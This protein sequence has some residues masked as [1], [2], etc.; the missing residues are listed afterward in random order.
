[1]LV[2]D[3]MTHTDMTAMLKTAL[4]AWA[5]KSRGYGPLFAK[6]SAGAHEIMARALSEMRVLKP[7]M[8]DW[9]W[10]NEHMRF[11]GTCSQ[12]ELTLVHEIMYYFLTDLARGRLEAKEDADKAGKADGISGKPKT[13]DGHKASSKKSRS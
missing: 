8:F 12:R 7:G 4:V 1:M 3:T 11:A 6:L 10:A 5:S 9:W 2:Q 13:S